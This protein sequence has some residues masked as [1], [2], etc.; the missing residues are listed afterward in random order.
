MLRRTT[1][2]RE[3]RAAIPP[4]CVSGVPHIV[5][6]PLTSSRSTSCALLFD[7][8]LQHFGLGRGVCASASVRGDRR[9]SARRCVMYFS[10][11]EAMRSRGPPLIHDPIPIVPRLYL[12]P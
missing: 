6:Q 12:E 3:H 4:R 11:P 5:D 9:C 2:S 8:E 10:H 1:I 7:P